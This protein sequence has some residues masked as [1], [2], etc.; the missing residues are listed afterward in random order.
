MMNVV[1]LFMAA[2]QAATA[3]LRDTSA[4]LLFADSGAGELQVVVACRMRVHFMKQHR[5]VAYQQ[6]MSTASQMGAPTRVITS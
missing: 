5:R 6:K 2:L 3:P 4:P 1:R